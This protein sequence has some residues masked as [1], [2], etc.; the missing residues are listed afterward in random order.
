[1]RVLL[2]C[3]R[4]CEW[5]H[6]RTRRGKTVRSSSGPLYGLQRDAN[7]FFFRESLWCD[8]QAWDHCTDDCP[9]MLFLLRLNSLISRKVQNDWNQMSM[10]S[11]KETRAP[12][13]NIW[14]QTKTLTS[15]F[16]RGHPEVPSQQVHTV[17]RRCTS[18]KSAGSSKK[19]DA[20]WRC[21]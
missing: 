15:S 1:M 20:L 10:Q 16:A 12:K 9:W 2:I 4:A 11:L 14:K 3:S 19:A 21:C 13:V 8:W 7:C 17:E 5:P 6:N 18:S